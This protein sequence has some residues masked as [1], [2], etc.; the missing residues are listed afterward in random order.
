MWVQSNLALKEKIRDVDYME[1]PV[2]HNLDE[3]LLQDELEEVLIED[4]NFWTEEEP[5]TSPQ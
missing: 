2:H 3:S 1:T 4:T 5:T